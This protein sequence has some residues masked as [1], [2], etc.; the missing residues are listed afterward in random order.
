[1]FC[2]YCGERLSEG[3]NFCTRCGKR[4]PQR[5]SPAVPA[6][7]A[8]LAAVPAPRRPAG[9]APSRGGGARPARSWGS[10]LAAALC[11]AASALAVACVAMALFAPL[12]ET[13]FFA[14]TSTAR[15]DAVQ[16]ALEVVDP[17]LSVVAGGLI[18]SQGLGAYDLARLGVQLADVRSDDLVALATGLSVGAAAVAAALC[19]AGAATT[20][21][22]RRSTP[23]LIV[24]TLLAAL[25]GG[26]GIGAASGLNRSLADWLIHDMSQPFREMG[27]SIIPSDVAVIVATPWLVAT[28]VCAAIAFACAVWARRRWARGRRRPR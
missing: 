10:P 7:Q 1:M 12:V 5:V 23:V 6:A 17:R 13:P 15:G 19:A 18:G 4:L 22:L 8:Q 14:G 20:L 3:D 2:P 27:V 21:A 11:A 16:A 26:A 24:G 25:L 28:V 9:M